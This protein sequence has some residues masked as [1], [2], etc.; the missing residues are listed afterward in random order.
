LKLYE[1]ILRFATW[2]LVYVGIYLFVIDIIF[3]LGAFNVGNYAIH[4]LLGWDEI[5]YDRLFPYLALIHNSL[6][7]IF[8]IILNERKFYIFLLIIMFF[9]IIDYLIISWA[10]GMPTGMMG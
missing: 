3:M 8:S 4:D 7:L 9:C 5:R 10:I 6:L 2:G 1:N